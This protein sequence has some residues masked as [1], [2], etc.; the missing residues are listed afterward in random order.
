MQLVRLAARMAKSE[1]KASGLRVRQLQNL[2]GA[3]DKA[4]IDPED[5]KLFGALEGRT[6]V[7]GYH[8]I[9]DKSIPDKSISDKSKYF[10]F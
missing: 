4:L 3:D 6:Q 7:G 10:G 1:A 2:R 9:P 5:E 8:W